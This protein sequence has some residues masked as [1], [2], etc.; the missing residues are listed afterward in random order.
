MVVYELVIGDVYGVEEKQKVP[1][2]SGGL[3]S[4]CSIFLFCS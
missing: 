3:G 2:G 1:V 4:F